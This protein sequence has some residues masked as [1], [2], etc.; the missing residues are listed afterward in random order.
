MT[1]DTSIVYTDK[2]VNKNLY[3]KKTYKHVQH[4]NDKRVN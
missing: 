2:D 4:Y 3:R 1:I